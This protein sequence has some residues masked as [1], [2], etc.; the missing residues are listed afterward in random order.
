MKKIFILIPLNVWGINLNTESITVMDINSG[1]VF[2]SKNSNSKRLIASTTKIMTAILAIESGKLDNVVTVGDEVLTMYGSNT[3]IE[4]GENIL[5]LDLVYGLMLRSG[6]DASVSIATYV[7]GSV[8]GF[9]DLMNKKAKELKMVDTIYAN[10]HGLD[11]ETK[12][13]STAN[14]LAILYSYAY[15][16]SIFKDIV[17]TK[18]YNTS[19]DIKSYT[20]FNKN[21][22]LSTYKYATGGKTGYTPSAKRVLVTSASK[23]KLNI[24]SA[25]FNNIYDYDLHTKLYNEIFL[26]YELTSILDKDKF[27]VNDSFYNGKI[28][29]K[30]SFAY[31]LMKEE[32]A[33]IKTKILLEKDKK[34][35]NDS[36]IGYIY[37]Y[38]NDE[39]IHKEPVYIKVKSKTIIEKIKDIFI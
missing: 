16:N 17:S 25:S 22:L 23:D 4:K 35:K 30:E 34:Y 18:K 15:Q 24:V 33:L 29:I 31:P 19:S 13:Y 36:R 2:F 39:I 21:K 28:Y 14:D 38:L 20:W 11:E 12:N 3:Y 26:N 27:Y 7:S 5:L 37:V 10:P 8:D 32:Q 6:N 1:R 9:V